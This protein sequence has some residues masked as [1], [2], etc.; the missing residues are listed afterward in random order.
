MSTQ[1]FVAIHI[2]MASLDHNILTMMATS[3]FLSQCWPR[4]LSLGHNELAMPQINTYHWQLLGSSITTHCWPA[5]CWS[6]T[7]VW[8][9]HKDSVWLVNAVKIPP[10]ASANKIR[11][12]NYN[13]SYLNLSHQS[14]PWIKRWGYPGIDFISTCILLNEILYGLLMNFILLLI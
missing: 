5:W 12:I 3:H 11:V 2:Y 10:A 1:I 9:N 8:N 13:E 7:H 4:S 6:S 14:F